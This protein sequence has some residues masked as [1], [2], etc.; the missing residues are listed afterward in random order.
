MQDYDRSRRYIPHLDNGV[1][2]L[3]L[4][5]A[6]PIPPST[7]SAR[8]AGASHWWL[9]ESEPLRASGTGQQ[10]AMH[11]FLEL[12]RRWTYR[13]GAATFSCA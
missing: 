1:L 2:I 13:S 7:V 10:E 12:R 6:V 5:W 8:D 9:L 4:Q 3:H 11:S